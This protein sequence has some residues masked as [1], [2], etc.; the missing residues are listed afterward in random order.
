MPNLTATE[1][2]QFI[3]LRND[4]FDR[5]TILQKNKDELSI[6]VKCPTIN[7]EVL[8]PFASS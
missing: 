7:L 2:E 6:S 8:I 4:K 5:S 3:D 1:K